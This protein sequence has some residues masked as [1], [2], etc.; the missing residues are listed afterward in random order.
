MPRT[1][2]TSFKK[3]LSF[4]NRSLNSSIG[5]KIVRLVTGSPTYKLLVSE[6]NRLRERKLEEKV[7][8]SPLPNHIAIIMD[9]NRRYA[10]ETGLSKEESYELGR[11]KLQEVLDWCMSL[12]IKIVTVYAFSTEN[13]RRDKS[14][15]D[16]L[17]RICS[18]EL[19]RALND[20]R[21]HKNQVRVNVIGHLD[22]LPKDIKEK[23]KKLM[24]VTKD[25]SNYILNVALAYGGRQE[26]VDAITKI[27]KDVKD[28]KLKVEEI[29]EKTVS[30]YLYTRG[31]PDPD[32]ILRTSGEE[33]ISNF[34]LWQLAY[35]ELY[36]SDVYWPA[37]KKRDLLEAIYIYQQ[38]KRRFGK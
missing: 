34:L 27:A 28:G 32:L 4:I 18:R 36:F 15:V 8:S 37:F 38:R 11:D 25:Y 31:M 7:R 3:L 17:L 30:S 9:G 24:E 33:R 20:P 1:R 19:D 12:G 6:L 22:L 2:G 35:S 21:I 26:I 10:L 29:D 5:K 14:E 13:F 16:Y 23:A